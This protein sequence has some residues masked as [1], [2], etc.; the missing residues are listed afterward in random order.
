MMARI[1]ALFVVL[2]LVAP[3]TTARAQRT[4]MPDLSG[5]PADIQAIWKKVQNGGRPTMDEAQ[6]LGQYLAAHSGEIQSMAQRRADSARV[7]APRAAKAALGESA[8]PSKACPA[9]SPALRSVPAG[10]ISDA[11]ARA[12]IDSISQKYLARETPAAARQLQAGFAR[13]TDAARLDATAGMLYLAGYDGAAIVGHAAAIRRGGD[14]AQRYWT[15]LGAT[16]VS[17]GDAASAITALRRAMGIGAPYAA[18]VHELGVAYADLGDLAAADSLLTSVTRTAPTFGLAWDALARVQSCEGRMTAAWASLAKAQEVDWSAR[19]ERLLAKHDPESKDDRV[20][21]QKPYEEPSG[22]S[23][24][25]PPPAPPPAELSTQT[26]VLGDTW[27]ENLGH[28]AQFIQT[29]NAYRELLV[30]ILREG[31]RQAAAASRA[32]DAA[33]RQS[34]PASGDVVVSVALSNDRAVIAALEKNRDRLSARLT[35]V[36][37]AY[38]DRDSAITREA[39]ARQ[40]VMLD[41]YQACLRATK[42]EEAQHRVCELPFCRAKLASFTKYYESSRDNG[43]VFFGG[44]V[45]VGTHYDEIMREWFMRAEKPG[46]RIT[47]DAERRYQLVGITMTM[48]TVA[49]TIG[50][51][52][53]PSEMCFDAK[54]IAALEALA[55]KAAAAADPG[56]CKSIDLSVHSVASIAGDCNHVRMTIDLEALPVTPTL[57]YKRATHDH[58]GS[59]FMGGGKEFVHGAVAGEA[60]LQVNFDEGGWVQ[61][62]GPAASVTVGSES[63][64]TVSANGM[65]NLLD[66]GPAGQAGVKL[67]GPGF[68]LSLATDTGFTGHL[69]P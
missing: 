8:D 55:A 19:R 57:D 14:R 45:G 40:K 64:V 7:A 49:A 61:G 59:L 66:H 2:L 38:V 63:L 18:L 33:A 47:I 25:P 13:I 3:F 44:M 5:A 53:P 54:Q 26:P 24:F 15:N 23:I 37:Q 62:F 22:K 43:R 56:T 65:V 31:D 51:N 52:D 34:A 42:G 12:F 39:V 29:A 60:G 32:E 41:Q 67:D 30:T 4:G 46:T 68:E 17:A 50:P 9:R 21:A 28:P 11:T 1:G 6:K 35:M 16:L 20:E 69:D 48:F 36:H 27:T 10:A 58:A